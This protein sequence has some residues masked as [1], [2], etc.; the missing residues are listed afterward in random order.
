MTETREP[1]VMEVSNRDQESL[2]MNTLSVVLISPDFA[3]RLRLSKALA[4]PQASVTREV[5][6]YPDI[7]DLAP[8]VEDCDVVIL[9][10][11]SDAERALDLVEAICSRNSSVTVMVYSSR[12]DPELLVRCMRVGARE[13]LVEPV[14][15]ATIAEALVRASARRQ[16]IHRQKKAT[17]KLLVFCG[18]KGGSGITTLATNFAVALTKESAAKVVLVDLDLQL[19]DVALELGLTT[20]FSVVDALEGASRL[21]SAFLSTLIEKHSS[22]LKVLAGPDS[23]GS[24]P[25]LNDGAKKMLAI[26]RNDFEYVVVDAGSGLDTFREPLLE[27]ADCIYLIS[28]V[29]IPALRNS[30]RL[31]SKLSDSFDDRKLQ[32][33]LNRFDSRSVEI[34][35]AAITKALTRPAKWKL[36]NDYASVRRA[37]NTGIPVVMENSQLSRVLFDM[38]RAAC[39]K[40]A[41]LER[42]KKKFSLFG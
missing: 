11:D 30:H 23:Y 35:D 28:E 32:I 17:G 38:A 19:G 27:M 8:I 16:E 7:D 36:P 18:V 33:V 39:G 2:S 5:V 20:K 34:D 24:F 37:Q 21:D 31:I 3:R 40:T 15:H 29:T 25:S 10:L 22:G 26:L 14:A 9:D 1:L 42:K 12:N 13:Y 41:S 4:N 6:D